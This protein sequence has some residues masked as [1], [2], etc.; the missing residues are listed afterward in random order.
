HLLVKLLQPTLD[1]TV[2]NVLRLA[3]VTCRLRVNFPLRLPY[4]LRHI[5]P[6]HILRTS[7]SHVHGQIPHEPTEVLRLGNEVRL[8]VDFD[9]DADAAVAVDVGIHQAV[10]S[11]ASGLLCRLGQ[12][13]LPQQGDGLLDVTA[14]LHEGVLAVFDP[15]L[16]ALT[17]LFHHLHGDLGHPFHPSNRKAAP[18]SPKSG[19]TGPPLRYTSISCSSSSSSTSP[20]ASAA[21]SSSST[22]TS[23]RPSRP[24][25]TASAIL[26]V[27]RRTA[28]MASSLPGMT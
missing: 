11:D 24:S 5:V 3:L 16:R 17:E 28:R 13:F 21:S 18:G 19:G 14:G 8:A 20:L 4:V 1:D 2:D 25:M 6:A 10:R 15:R 7:R 27:S 22:S 12:P 9:E 26:L 23:C